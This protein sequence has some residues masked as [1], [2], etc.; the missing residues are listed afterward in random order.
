MSGQSVTV[1]QNPR[2]SKD[3]LTMLKK[4]NLECV[5]EGIAGRKWLQT[6]FS[7]QRR[8][9]SVDA[10]KILVSIRSVTKLWPHK[11]KRQPFMSGYI[12]DCQIQRTR[13]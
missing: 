7:Y 4:S 6:M 10:V 12:C 11:T 8:C 2:E 5:G 9:L 1:N 3:K 13:D